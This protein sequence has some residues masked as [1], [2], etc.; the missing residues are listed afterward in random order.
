MRYHIGDRSQSGPRTKIVK[1]EPLAL[2]SDGQS[3]SD[4]PPDTVPRARPSSSANNTPPLRWPGIEAI[5]EAYQQHLQGEYLC[6]IVLIEGKKS[7]WLT[8]SF[9]MIILK[10]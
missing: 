5:M 3:G 1:E 2:S 4:V 8:A 7:K 6:P 10:I 9:V